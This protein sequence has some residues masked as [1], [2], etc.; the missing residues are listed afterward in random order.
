MWAEIIPVSV[1]MRLIETFDIS[2]K[3]MDKYEIRVAVFDTKELKMMDDEGT[4][5]GFIKCFF[6]SKNAKET[7]THYRNQNGACSFNYRLL[8]NLE[9]P[10]KSKEHYKLKVQAYDRDFFKSNDL[11]GEQSLDLQPVIRDSEIAVRP[12]CVTKDYYEDYL[13]PEA[14]W[15]D[16]EFHED[17]QSFWVKM[18]SKNEKGEIECNGQVRIQID[19]YPIADAELNKVGNAREEPNV[20]PYL[21][22]PVGRLTLS[23]N[24]LKMLEQM[25]GAGFRRKLYTYLCIALCCAICVMMFPMIFSNLVTKGILGIFG[26]DG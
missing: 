9:H 2:P 19:V 15:P 16:I 6:D 4:T 17:K 25:V 18:L 3:P 24:P 12:M 22:L 1:D 21:P 23:L 10:A 13:K 8:F 26:L 14:G 20:N 11:I 5:D 7:D